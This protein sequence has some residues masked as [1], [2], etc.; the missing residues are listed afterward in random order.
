MPRLTRVCLR[1]TT[2]GAAAGWAAASDRVVS[3]PKIA[4]GDLDIASWIPDAIADDNIWVVSANNTDCGGSLV[5]VTAD[6]GFGNGR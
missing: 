4:G 3:V 1:S 6:E 2:A 5:Q